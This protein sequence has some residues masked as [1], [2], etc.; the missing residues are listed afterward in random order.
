M[1]DQLDFDLF[2]PNPGNRY[3]FC[4]PL[5]RP[6]NIST[7]DAEQ[8]IVNSLAKTPSEKTQKLFCKNDSFKVSTSESAMQSS[9]NDP[10]ISSCIVCPHNNNLQT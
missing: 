2:D 3:I 1:L 9:S 5:L 4:R 10:L 6:V 7:I 8:K